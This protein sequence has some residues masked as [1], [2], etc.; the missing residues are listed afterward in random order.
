MLND[1]YSNGPFSPG[2]DKMRKKTCTIENRKNSSK[3]FYNFGN[4]FV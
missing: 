2:F 1:F 4:I 3:L